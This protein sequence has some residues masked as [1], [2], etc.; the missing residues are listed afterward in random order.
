[1]CSNVNCFCEKR[2]QYGGLSYWN[3]CYG[4]F[5]FLMFVVFLSVFA[6]VPAGARPRPTWGLAGGYECVWVSSVPAGARPRPTWGL[7]RGGM[8][9]CGCRRH[10]RGHAPALLGGWRGGMN[11][12]GCRRYRR[13]HAPA[14]LGGWRGGYECVWVSSVSAG[15]RPHPTFAGLSVLRRSRARR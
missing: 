9:V 8:N 3:L 7:A 11:V 1:M 15:A 14:L 5:L 4:V 2:F 12:C 10:R 6:S 13:G